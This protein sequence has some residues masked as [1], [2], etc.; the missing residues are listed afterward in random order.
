MEPRAPSGGWRHDAAALAELLGAAARALVASPYRARSIVRLPARGRLV[1]TGDVHDN[2]LHFEAAVR[3]ARLDASR[4]HH[5]VLQEIIHGESPIDGIDMS[6]RLLARVAELVCAYPGQVHPLLANH[7]IAQLR[8]HSIAK[9]GV[10]CTAAFDL[11]LIEAYGDESELAAASVGRFIAAMPLAVRCDNGL[12]VSHSLPS[13]TLMRH[14]DTRVLERDLHDEDF[15]PPYGA[16]HLMTWGRVHREEQL[17]DLAA[18]WGVRAFVVGHE[19]A[20]DGVAYLSPNLVILNT[21]HARGRVVVVDLAAPVPE[22]ADLAAD[23]TPVA[24]WLPDLPPSAGGA[25]FA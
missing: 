9:G 16:A 18:E 22:A 1:V 2:T 6:H 11:G 14:F 13:A 24:A 4:D 20:P 23:A 12:L 8:G 17:R 25:E 5:L 21:G 3:A 19:P 7:E 15:D 10:N